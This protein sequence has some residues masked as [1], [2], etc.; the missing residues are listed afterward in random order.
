LHFGIQ[1]FLTVTQKQ[2]LAAIDFGGMI[3][4]L[5]LGDYN[6]SFPLSMN[7]LNAMLAGDRPVCGL[8]YCVYT[9]EQRKQL[10]RVL[11]FND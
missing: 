3:S 7:K 5:I 6:R 11:R 10:V 2:L 4:L 9:F 1:H 8:N